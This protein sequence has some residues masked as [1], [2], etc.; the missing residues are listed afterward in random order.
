MNEQTMSKSETYIKQLE[1]LAK[2]IIADYD[3]MDR[4]VSDEMIMFNTVI[5]N[6]EHVRIAHQ[7]LEI[8]TTQ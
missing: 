6:M 8:N 5:Q 2:K 3:G 7:I 1:D 4:S